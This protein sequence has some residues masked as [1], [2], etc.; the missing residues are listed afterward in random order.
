MGTVSAYMP[1]SDG[2]SQKWCRIESQIE[3]D[4]IQDTRIEGRSLNTLAV[5]LKKC[6]PEKQQ[7]DSFVWIPK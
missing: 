7:W 6:E 2:R 1:F 5:N 3:I 4:K